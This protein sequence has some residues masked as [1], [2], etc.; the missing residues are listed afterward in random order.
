LPSES[1]EREDR[2]VRVA[3][4]AAAQKKLMNASSHSG[5]GRSKTHPFH[6]GLEG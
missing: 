6:Q 5:E 1:D 4:T 3:T 2:T